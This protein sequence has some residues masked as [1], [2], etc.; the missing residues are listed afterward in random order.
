MKVFF[1]NCNGGGFAAEIEV[2][3]GMTLGGLFADKMPG[4]H[5]G[6]YL[7]RLNRARGE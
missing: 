6:D 4:S 1:I 5:P 7:I 2:P 3:N